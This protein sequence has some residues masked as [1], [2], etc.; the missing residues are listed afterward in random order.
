MVPV[1]V[2]RRVGLPQKAA[3]GTS[4]AAVIPIA[5]VAAATYA[6]NRK[7]D[8]LAALCIIPSS[9]VG[10]VLGARLI[11]RVPDHVLAGAFG[12]F[13]LASAVRLT[14]PVGLPQTGQAASFGWLT[15]LTLVAG[16]AVMGV[17]GGL[18]GV[19]GGVILVPLLVL[20]FGVSQ[21]LA[22]GTSLAAII[23]TALGGAAS[24]QHLGNVS[25]PA[26]RLLAIGGMA[27]AVAGALLAV[28]TRE[29]PLRLIFAA[30]LAATGL[31]QLQ[32]ARELRRREPMPRP[33]AATVAAP[34][35][36][37]STEPEG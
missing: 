31:R 16:G 22:Q 23:P 13:C 14:V 26:A 21:Q 35:T 7:V 1:L 6:S 20:G 2:S 3:T 36:P 12:V 28:H 32:R 29:E 27:G 30:Y 34:L 11:H 5:A 24:H 33:Q 9:V 10:V 18:I 4:L 25:I 8:G 17:L 37:P 19:G 15:V